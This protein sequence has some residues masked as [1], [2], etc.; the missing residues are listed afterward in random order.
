MISSRVIFFHKDEASTYSVDH[1]SCSSFIKELYKLNKASKANIDIQMI[2]VDGGDT[3]FGMSAYSAIK[4]SRSKTIASCSGT[5]ASMGTIILQAATTR[6]LCQHSS[7]MI[8][9]GSIEMD[10]SAK[11][12]KSYVDANEKFYRQMLTIYSE[13]CQYGEFFKA[14][15]FALGRIRSYLDTKIKNTT[16]WW[17]SPEEALYYGFVDKIF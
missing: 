16:D 2:S 13:R 12:C 6:R 10:D 14:R 11:A 3:E 5:T 7:F 15:K 8:H 1:R 9:A 4:N 17:M